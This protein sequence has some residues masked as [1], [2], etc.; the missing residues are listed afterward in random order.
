MLWRTVQVDVWPI[1]FEGVHCRGTK[2]LTTDLIPEHNQGVRK[3]TGGVV[4]ESALTG[5]RHRGNQKES[6][7]K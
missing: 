7:S 3:Q 6:F 1:V 5:Y 2:M 4:Y